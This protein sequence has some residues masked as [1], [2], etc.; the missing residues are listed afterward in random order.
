MSNKL[1]SRETYED[2][3]HDIICEMLPK[4]NR[5]NIRPTYQ[6]N[7]G[8]AVNNVIIDGNVVAVEGFSKSSNVIYLT[9][10]FDDNTLD[11]FTHPDGSVDVTRWF[12]L[13]LN[14][15]G[16]QSQE[17]ALIL[18]SLFRQ[19]QIIMTLENNGI[20]LDST[21]NINQLNE[22][23]NGEVWERRDLTIRFNEN[24][25]LP[26]PQLNKIAVADL[27]ILTLVEED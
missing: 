7:G 27:E 17:V 19:D 25:I 15:Y 9:V 12:D 26:V 11:A 3:F 8:K 4:F 13:K 18:K 21:G 2:F 10:I 16:D 23:I 14:V 22:I 1:R 20:V 24:V 6:K 5:S